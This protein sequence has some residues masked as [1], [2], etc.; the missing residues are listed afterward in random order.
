M[1]PWW[2]REHQA[3][4]Q[5]AGHHQASAWR[6]RTRWTLAEWLT[7]KSDWHL[8]VIVTHESL[9][10]AL[11]FGW[12]HPSDGSEM[13]KVLIMF[14][15][16]NSHVVWAATSSVDVRLQEKPLHCHHVL[17][18]LQNINIYSLLSFRILQ[19]DSPFFMARVL[20]PSTLWWTRLRDGA[21]RRKKKKRS[22]SVGWIWS[23]CP[24][25]SL[26]TLVREGWVRW[27][28]WSSWPQGRS[29]ASF[30]W[31]GWVRW[32]FRFFQ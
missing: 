5:E 4:R 19:D 2:F 20:V 30:N 17:K 32:L 31:E 9:L 10:S 11:G 21:Q 25:D 22:E 26:L 8:R 23:N 14:R 15:L 3:G 1:L 29:G 6:A 27:L 12:N 13:R 18:D 7:S 16:Y 28:I 24:R